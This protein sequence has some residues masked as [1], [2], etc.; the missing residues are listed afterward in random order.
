MD[1][2]QGFRL[3]SNT[4]KDC[5]EP[6]AAVKFAE[7]ES[8]TGFIPSYQGPIQKS[9]MDCDISDQCDSAYGSEC[10]STGSRFASTS[11]VSERLKG[12][13]IANVRPAPEVQP[14]SFIKQEHR[15]SENSGRT[16]RAQKRAAEEPEDVVLTSDAYDQD[17]EGDTY[18]E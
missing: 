1:Q 4:V 11:D 10:L 5:G 6:A 7:T 3:D 13:H 17:E 12:L 16:V 14:G 9:V 18:V 15:S 2:Y 8:R